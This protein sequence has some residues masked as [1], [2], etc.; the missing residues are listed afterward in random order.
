MQRPDSPLQHR[1]QGSDDGRCLEPWG[2]HF[3]NGRR[4]HNVGP[5]S[6]G[7]LDIAFERAG[8]A[9]QVLRRGELERVHE[10]RGDNALRELPGAP[11]KREM[12][13][14]QGAHRRNEADPLA[15][16]ARIV[17]GAAEV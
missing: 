11:D 14:V 13:L 3:L 12:S 7:K 4:E 10:H 1:A 2:I 15:A 17:T 6:S 5:R 16:G 9:R 8:I